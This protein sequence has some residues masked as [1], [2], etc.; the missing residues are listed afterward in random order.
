MTKD[1]CNPYDDYDGPYVYPVSFE[2]DN[3]EYLH[4]PSE[5]DFSTQGD[6][7]INEAV[8]NLKS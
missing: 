3:K 1:T 2:A 5:T 4:N 6:Y 8:L 7:F